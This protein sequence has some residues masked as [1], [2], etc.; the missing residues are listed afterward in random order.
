M[1][2]QGRES[3]VVIHSK[4]D[5]VN[6][7][8]RG[9]NVMKRGIPNTNVSPSFMPRGVITVRQEGDVTGGRETSE[10]EHIRTKGKFY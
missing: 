5:M 1:R 6:S 7:L 9:R 2:N 10:I 8:N 3:E 4:R